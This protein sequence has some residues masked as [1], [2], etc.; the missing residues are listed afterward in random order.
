MISI[1]DK[2]SNQISYE[3]YKVLRISKSI[4]HK[5]FKEITIVLKT[6]II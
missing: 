5:C 4:E 1:K 3:Y 6:M 2:T